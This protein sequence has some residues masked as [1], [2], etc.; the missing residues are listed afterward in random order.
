MYR[1]ATVNTLRLLK[2]DLQCSVSDTLLMILII[3]IPI[4]FLNC[5]NPCSG[6]GSSPQDNI[7]YYETKKIS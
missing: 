4:F 3:L 6:W 1:Q 5:K 2:S 7:I